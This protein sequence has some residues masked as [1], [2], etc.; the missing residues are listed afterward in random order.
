MTFPI[1]LFAQVGPHCLR[2]VG[3]HYEVQFTACFEFAVLEGIVHIQWFT[4]DGHFFDYALD[5]K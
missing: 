1:F 2:F 3:R 5:F 4:V